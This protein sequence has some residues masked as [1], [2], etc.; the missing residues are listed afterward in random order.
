MVGRLLWKEL[1]ES[2]LFVLIAAI[3]PPA[4]LWFSGANPFPTS[5]AASDVINYAGVLC[6]SVVVMV[7][8]I[9]KG[10]RRREEGKSPLAHLPANRFFEQA[11]SVLLPLV[12][13]ALIG[14]WAGNHVPI[15]YYQNPALRIQAHDTAID[16]G[17]LY[18]IAGFAGCYLLAAA[19]SMWMGLLCGFVWSVVGLNWMTRSDYLIAN[20]YFAEGAGSLLVRTALASMACLWLYLMLRRKSAR[21]ARIA[22]IGLLAAVVFVPI[23]YGQFFDPHV[24]ERYGDNLRSSDR[25]LE[26]MVSKD[27][28]LA[29][30]DMRSDTYVELPSHGD[31]GLI[32]FDDARCA[33]VVR[34]AKGSDRAEIVRWDGVTVVPL[35]TIA[36]PE[37]AIRRSTGWLNCRGSVSPDRQYLSCGIRSSLGQG[38]DL[39]IVDLRSGLGW[40]AFPIT[41]PP[42]RATW[43]GRRAVFSF[44]DRLRTVDLVTMK[45]GDLHIPGKDGG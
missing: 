38:T 15:Q 33:Y 2:W 16:F 31:V 45:T 10:S 11:V 8:A 37:G 36:V 24:S 19:L 30:R 25:S 4:M 7:W 35:A 42:A 23:I 14:A 29:W 22:P 13:S 40:I 12:I 39:W 34:Q 44:Y 1:R 32:A 18:L 26:L 27:N 3:A 21:I 9:R 20:S 41:Y 6:S 5:K 17:I 28:V 43:L